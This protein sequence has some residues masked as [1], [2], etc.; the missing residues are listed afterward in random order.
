MIVERSS[1][2]RDG[3]TILK[4]MC[5]K[6]ISSGRHGNLVLEGIEKVGGQAPQAFNLEMYKFV[7]DG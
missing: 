7:V 4:D 6:E 5:R 3:I 1:A 2:W